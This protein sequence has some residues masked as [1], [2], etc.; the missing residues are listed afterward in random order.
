[1]QTQ[2]V[3]NGTACKDN[4]CKDKGSCKDKEVQE[5]KGCNAK[6]CESKAG[7]VNM[8]CAAKGNG[9]QTSDGSPVGLSGRV[10]LTMGKT[11]TIH[12]DVEPM[13]ANV[14]IIAKPREADEFVV[15]EDVTGGNQFADTDSGRKAK[16]GKGF[17]WKVPTD[18]KL[19]NGEKVM[20]R[21]Y[22]TDPKLFDPK[23]DECSEDAQCDDSLAFKVGTSRRRQLHGVGGKAYADEEEEGHAAASPEPLVLGEGLA[24]V[25]SLV[26]DA[27]AEGQG[28]AEAAVGSTTPRR[29]WLQDE[30]EGD[31]ASAETLFG[32]FFLMLAIFCAL[33]YCQIKRTR[34]NAAFAADSAGTAMSVT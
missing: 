6:K 34:E 3:N 4:A 29:R 14:K 22:S 16:Q 7:T 13:N 5:E 15:A 8:C 31:C 23:N 20:L 12:W 11:Y 21:V 33:L 2:K 24:L 25:P 28:G 32:L 10:K 30:E 26:A 9:V 19:R 1:M 17:Q 18:K 27:D